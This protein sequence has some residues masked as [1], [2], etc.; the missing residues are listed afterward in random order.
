MSRT[1]RKRGLVPVGSPMTYKVIGSEHSKP[2]FPV[3][4]MGI[5]TTYAFWVVKVDSTTCA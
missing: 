4:Q 1:L 3:Y 2:Q 5:N